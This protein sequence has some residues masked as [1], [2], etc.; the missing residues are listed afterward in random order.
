VSDVQVLF[1]NISTKDATQMRDAIRA[2]EKGES[3]L[4]GRFQIL[5]TIGMNGE[6]INNESSKQAGSTESSAVSGEEV[7]G[8][9]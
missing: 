3:P 8:T 9:G 7:G 5:G 4:A 2:F 6:I 1:G